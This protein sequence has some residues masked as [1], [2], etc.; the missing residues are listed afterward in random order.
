MNRLVKIITIALSVMAFSTIAFGVD[1][2]TASGQILNVWTNPLNGDFG[3]TILT[4]ATPSNS[5]KITR[6]A[7]GYPSDA[8]IN[9]SLIVIFP[10]SSG[11]NKNALATALMAKMLGISVSLSFNLRAHTDDKVVTASTYAELAF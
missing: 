2:E 9:S 6:Y 10:S 5:T 11:Q 3:L 4:T 8:S 7:S 1:Y